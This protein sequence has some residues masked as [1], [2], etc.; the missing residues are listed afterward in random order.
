MLLLAIVSAWL[1]PITSTNVIAHVKTDVSCPG[2]CRLIVASLQHVNGEYAASGRGAECGDTVQL[3]RVPFGARLTP[4]VTFSC[5]GRVTSETG[6]P[7]TL[8]P[9]LTNV[10]VADGTIWVPALAEPRGDE[11]IRLRVRGEGFDLSQ[12]FV[13]RE[14]VIRGVNPPTGR[15]YVS[16]TLEPWG[17]ASNTRVIFREEPSAHLVATG[18]GCDSGMSVLPLVFF[19]R[20][21]FPFPRGFC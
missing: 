15:L 11:R 9:Y 10:S 4:K 20:R 18:V 13:T 7:L 14:L 1:D 21:R 6:A 19:R 17:I 16:A 5:D 2:E 12:D 3:E 8:A